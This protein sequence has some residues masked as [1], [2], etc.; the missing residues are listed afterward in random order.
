MAPADFCGSVHRRRKLGVL[1]EAVARAGELQ[2]GRSMRGTA[3]TFYTQFVK[4]LELIRIYEG[5]FGRY[6]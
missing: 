6:V 3:C 5:V 2:Q 4:V 1:E